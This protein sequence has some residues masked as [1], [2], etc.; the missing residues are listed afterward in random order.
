MATPPWGPHETI[1]LLKMQ[2]HN[3]T[4]GPTNWDHIEVSVINS[5]RGDA[6]TRIVYRRTEGRTDRRTTGYRIARLVSTSRAKKW[7]WANSWPGESVSDLFRAKI[8]LSDSL[9]Y[10]VFS[11]PEPKALLWS[12]V[13][14]PPIVFTSPLNRR[15]Q[16]NLTG[17]K[18]STFSTKFVFSGRSEKQDALTSDWLRHFRLFWTAERNSRKPDR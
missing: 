5:L 13:V 3:Y 7:S 18:N 12:R 11:A 2:V 4:I 14:R 8:R 6:I 15:I 1:S 9:L 10:T 16:G 17:S